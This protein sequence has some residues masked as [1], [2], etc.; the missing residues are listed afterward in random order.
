MAIQ[1]GSYHDGEGSIIII[2]DPVAAGVVAVG[3]P[4]R[5]HGDD[6]ATAL[7]VTPYPSEMLIVSEAS[8]A[9]AGYERVG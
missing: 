3:G 1:P 4:T 5:F 9:A 7:R 8:L 6:I 2:A